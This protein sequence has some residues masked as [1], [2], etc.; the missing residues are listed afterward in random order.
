[1][2]YNNVQMK[3][4]KKQIVICGNY[5]IG[6]L[7]DEAILD[8]L[9]RL[10]ETCW[11]GAEICVLSSNPR[12][13]APE[14][15]IKAVQMF[16]AGLKSTLKFW[17]SGQFWPTVRAARRADLVIL[18]GGGLFTD[19][20]WRA[21]W[22]WAVQVWWF[23][24]LRRPYVCLAQSVGPLRTRSGRF[25]ARRV[26]RGARLCTLRDAQSAELLRELG[27]KKVTVFADAVF[28]LGYE[29]PRAINIQQYAVLSLREWG[30]NPAWLA[31]AGAVDW[32][33]REQGLRT[34]FIPFQESGD[35]DKLAYQK[36]KSLLSEKPA[37]EMKTVDDYKQALEMIGRSRLVLGMRLHSLIFAAL[38]C[39]PFVGISYSSKVRAM[40]LELG[41]E[42][43]C[44][45]FD[46]LSSEE[47]IAALKQ[48]FAQEKQ[49]VG[50]LEQKKLQ[51]TYR[52]FEHEKALR[53]LIS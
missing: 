13:T 35:D 51:L 24:M 22:I 1:M 6:N 43:F 21:V 48:I 12:Q 52:F 7:G 4:D 18:G 33:W 30:N 38:F 47:L 15:G 8:G 29:A 39:R 5:G 32:L 14:H 20:K 17:L 25:L 50:G 36:V 31:V 10:S 40:T 27:V 45:D 41:M 42:N 49:L 2:H 34:I 26:F 46:K 9:I 37:M 11:P 44:L 23:R 53:D 28:A 3:A 16:P 19:E